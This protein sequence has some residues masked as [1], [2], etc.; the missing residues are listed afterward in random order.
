ML[1]FIFNLCIIIIKGGEKMLSK[2]QQIIVL[3]LLIVNAI[4]F[5]ITLDQLLK[6][7]ET[8]AIKCLTK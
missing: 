6:A 1:A 2:T 3:M 8:T 5:T 4:A 7:R